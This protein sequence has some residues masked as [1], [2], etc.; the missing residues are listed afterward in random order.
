MVY[1]RIGGQVKDIYTFYSV[2][3]VLDADETLEPALFDRIHQL[4][5]EMQKEIGQKAVA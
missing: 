1:Q 3:I 4:Y 5:L 2:T